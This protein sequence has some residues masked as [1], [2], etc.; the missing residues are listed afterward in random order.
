MAE[1]TLIAGVFEADKLLLLAGIAVASLWTPGPN[2][3]MLAS[4]GATFG[5]RAT[6]PHA[7]GVSL[8]FALMFFAVSV[9]LGEVFQ[10]SPGLRDGLKWGGAALM[11]YL[12]WRIA[13]AQRASAGRARSRP[14]TFVEAAAFQWVNPKAWTIAIATSAVFISGRAPLLE[15]A[16]AALIYA[17]IGLTSSHGWAGAG[18]AL[19]RFLSTDLRLRVFN[20]TMGA[21][22]VAYVAAM[23]LE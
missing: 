10:T 14:F 12:A 23:L 1:P 5:L 22:I 15:A 3:L 6:I 20:A 19:Q 9:A 4:S 11:L 21:L 8:G 7:L 2:N 18:A 16:G 13:T 17:M